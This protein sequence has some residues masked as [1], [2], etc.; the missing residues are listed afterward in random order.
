MPNTILHTEAGQ[1]TYIKGLGPI[2]IEPILAAALRDGVPFVYL[3]GEG[4]PGNSLCVAPSH[5]TALIRADH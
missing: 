2:D 5:V 4:Q 1:T 3:H